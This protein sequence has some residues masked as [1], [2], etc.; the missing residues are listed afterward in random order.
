MFSQTGKG[1]LMQRIASPNQTV[2]KFK[3]NMNG[4]GATGSTMAATGTMGGTMQNTGKLRG[5]ARNG[6]GMSSPFRET[7]ARGMVTGVGLLGKT[8]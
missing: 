2:S 5:L 7:I 6:S 8:Q 3:G 1:S 4:T